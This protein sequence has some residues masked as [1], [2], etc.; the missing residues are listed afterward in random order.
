MTVYLSEVCGGF[1]KQ[2]RCVQKL[3]GCGMG[4]RAG[5]VRVR[6]Q[7]RVRSVGVSAGGRVDGSACIG[8]CAGVDGGTGLAECGRGFASVQV[9]KCTG[10]QI[11]S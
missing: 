3:W 4:R 2:M 1:R 7:M 10:V 5:E 6:L 11:G 9:F 8:G